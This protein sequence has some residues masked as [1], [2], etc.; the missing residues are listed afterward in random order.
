MPTPDA[1]RRRS[2]TAHRSPAGARSSFRRGFVVSRALTQLSPTGRT[3]PDCEALTWPYAPV[4]DRLDALGRSLRP[5]PCGTVTAQGQWH[6]CTWP[7]SLPVVGCR[8]RGKREPPGRHG[9]PFRRAVHQRFSAPGQ[10]PG[11]QATRT[12][13]SYAAAHQ[14]GAFRRRATAWLRPASTPSWPGRWPTRSGFFRSQPP[15]SAEGEGPFKQGPGPGN[16]I[17]HDP[18]HARA[19]DPAKVSTGTICADQRCAAAVPPADGESAVSQA[20]IKP[21]PKGQH[22]ECG[23]PW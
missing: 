17:D 1:A 12:T 2:P 21:P 16:S 13:R 11:L 6:H 22:P 4:L 14:L 23:P 8:C 18:D 7:I 20:G 10:S 19:S 9:C 5:V 15:S 3:P